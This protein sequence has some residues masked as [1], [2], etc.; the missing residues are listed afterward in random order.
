MAIVSVGGRDVLFFC[1]G[2]VVLTRAALTGGF[3]HSPK[4]ISLI[5]REPE[6][7]ERGRRFGS[8]S[9]KSVAA[10]IGLMSF[11]GWVFWGIFNGGG[12]DIL[13]CA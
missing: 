1:G 4:S 3:G 2:D 11:R 12:F 8:S 5:G 13:E 7:F 6:K 10:L 9:S